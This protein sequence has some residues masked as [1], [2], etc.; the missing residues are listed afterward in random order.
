MKNAFLFCIGIASL[1]LAACNPKTESATPTATLV[2]PLAAV[3]PSV[4]VDQWRAA[5]TSAY[6]GWDSK[7]DAGLE[8][9]YA[10]F[11]IYDPVAK[12]RCTSGGTFAGERDAFKRVYRFRPALGRFAEMSAEYSLKPAA[13]VG[14]SMAMREC[15]RSPTV[16]ALVRFSGDNWLFVESFA[17]LA[18]GNLVLE[19]KFPYESVERDTIGRGVTERGATVLEPAEIAALKTIQSAQSV[20]VRVTGQ[21]GYVPMKDKQTKDLMKEIEQLMPALATVEKKLGTLNGQMCS[22]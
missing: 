20:Q 8:E 1:S 11:G 2:A 21:K 6:V 5:L 4:T 9:F 13:Y 19:K 7:Q 22:V 16:L 18:D 10:C 3:L 14:F 17:V 12:P 15:D